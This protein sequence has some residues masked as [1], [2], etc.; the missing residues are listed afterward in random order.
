MNPDTQD[1]HEHLREPP[2]SLRLTYT[3]TPMQNPA[4]RYQLALRPYGQTRL[5][6]RVPG[7]HHIWV[8]EI[9]A[10]FVE[11]ILT[12]LR[13]AGFPAVPALP[14]W[15]VPN[16]VITRIDIAVTGLEA[17]CEIELQDGNGDASCRLAL[18]LLE[19]IVFQVSEGAIG[20]SDTRMGAVIKELRK[21][22]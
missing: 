11:Q 18:Q 19:G 14:V 15:T 9:E 1:W 22:Q 17:G 4:E 16:S 5:D 2:R 13:M 7:L 6:Y 8:G 20:Q 3:V 21:I 10:A 12:A